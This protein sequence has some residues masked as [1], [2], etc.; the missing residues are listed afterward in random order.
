MPL[1]VLDAHGLCRDKLQNLS[2]ESQLLGEGSSELASWVLGGKNGMMRGPP[3]S[4]GLQVN[5][6]RKMRVSGVMTQGASRAGRAEYLKTFKVAYSL[7]GRKF[8][9]IQDASGSGDKVGPKRGYRSP[10]P[11]SLVLTEKQGILRDRVEANLQ[12]PLGP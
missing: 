5:L 7:D 10:H 11:K 4:P 2:G 9:F 6:L 8:E 12:L 3:F 1:G